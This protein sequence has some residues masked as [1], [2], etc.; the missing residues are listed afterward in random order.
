VVL[1]HR[2]GAY[3]GLTE[4]EAWSHAKLPL[5]PV[6]APSPDLA[7]NVSDTGYP[8]L[9]ASF[10]GAND[11][12]EEAGDARIAFSRYSRNR[13]T[14]YGTRDS[15]DWLAVDFGAPRTVSTIEIY[16]WGDD[17]GVRAPRRYTIQYWNGTRWLDARERSRLPERPMTGAVN[18]VRLAP[19]HTAR[20]RVVFAHDLPAVTGVTELTIEGPN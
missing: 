19:V 18:I 20:V 15:T 4:I 12:V 7:Y 3:T 13:W 10:T 9:T 2:R 1:T 14:A 6:T 8:R 11:R 5:A 16:L 17:R